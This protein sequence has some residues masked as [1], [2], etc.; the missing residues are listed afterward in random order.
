MSELMEQ[1]GNERKTERE[2]GKGLEGGIGL[3]PFWEE[4]S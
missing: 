4:R 3:F 1:E 2:V